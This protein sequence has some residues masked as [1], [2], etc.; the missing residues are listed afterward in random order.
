MILDDQSSYAAHVV[1][2][3]ADHDLAVL[4]INVPVGVKLVPVPLGTSADL[5]VGQSVFAIGNPFGLDQTLTTGV[6]SALKRTINGESGRPIENMIQTDAAI[7]PG[8][9]GGPLLDSAGRLIG[10]NSAIVSPS[11]A[12]SG[13]GFSIPVD[14][15]NRVVPEIIRTGHYT[16]VLRLGIRYQDEFSRCS[17]CVPRHLQGLAVTLVQP[18]SPAE[19]AGIVGVEQLRNGDYSLGDV[20]MKLDGTPIKSG[21]DL[22]A[23]MDRLHPGDEVRR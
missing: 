5:Q 14:T 7:N 2:F 13:I 11:G 17:C 22:I 16:R 12:S 21:D 8:N 10:V 23:Q 19:A 15:A 3:S 18:R 20:L 1:G 9:S 6:I 4:K